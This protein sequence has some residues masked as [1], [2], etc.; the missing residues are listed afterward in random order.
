M[1]T[2]CGEDTAGAQRHLVPG[3]HKTPAPKCEGL[4]SLLEPSLLAFGNAT[5][6]IW[7]DVL[8]WDYYACSC[9]DK[10]PKPEQVAS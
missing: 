2:A 9:A 6:L 5:L 10:R 8:V 4:E 7:L 1:G 3:K